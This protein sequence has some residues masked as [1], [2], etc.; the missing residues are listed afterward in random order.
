MEKGS[1]KDDPYRKAQNIASCFAATGIIN[2]NSVAI[3]Y[4]RP[5]FL[6][7]QI[8]KSFSCYANN[9]NT[10]KNK[11][12]STN[13][14]KHFPKKAD[15]L[16]KLVSCIPKIVFPVS[17]NFRFLSAIFKRFLILRISYR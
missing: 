15:T 7:N 5:I 13:I 17:K 8:Q 12:N 3:L 11:T 2:G 10:Q 16:V 4:K 14:S 6:S 1:G 9:C